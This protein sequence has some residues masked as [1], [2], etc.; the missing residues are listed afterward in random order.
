MATTRLRI[1][2][3]LEQSTIASSILYSNSSNEAAWFSPSL[4]SDRILF[5]D[6]SASTISWLSVGSGLTLS[7]TTISANVTSVNSQ[8][9]A[10]VLTTTSINEGTNLYFTDERVDDRVSN[11]L[12]A[13]TNITLTYNDVANTLTINASARAGGYATVQED[14]SNLTQRT[15]LNFVGAGITAS[16][17]VSKTDVTL[18]ATL[19]AL[20]AYNT[21]GLLT[22]T[23]ADTFTG[24]TL[25]APAA[26]ITITNPAGTA[27]NPTFAL[28]NDLAAVEALSGTGIAR[29]TGTDTWSVG[30]TVS[31]AEGGTG[32]TTVSHGGVLVGF[33]GN[34]IDQVIPSGFDAYLK[35]NN[36]SG[37]VAWDALSTADLSDNSN[38]AKL[39]ATQTFT[40]DNTFNNV[41]VNNVTPTLSTHLVNKSYVDNLLTGLDWKNSARVAS[42][43]NVAVTYNATG[44]TSARGQITGAPNTLDGI[45]LAANNRILLKDQSTGAQNG[46]WVVTTLGSG[47]N[48]VWDRA[49]DFDSDA[50]VTSGAAMF[51][52]EGTA[53]A[54]KAFVLTTNDPITI[55]G[56]SGT[57][58]TFVQFGGGTS[59]V[60]GAGLL[61]SG[62]ILN[63]QTASSARIV[64]N[65]DNIDLATTAVSSGTYGDATTAV[66]FSV[67]SYGRLTTATNVAIAVPASQITDFNEAAQDAVGNI[68]TDTA[69]IDFTYNDAGNTIT[70][71]VKDDSITFAKVQNISTARLLGRSTAG[72]GDI[73]QLTY[74][75]D[76]SAGVYY[77]ALSF[78]Y[79]QI[80]SGYTWATSEITQQLSFF[81]LVKG[82]GTL[83]EHDISQ[84]AIKI[85]HADTSSVSNLDTSAAQVIDTLTF[86]TYGHVQTVTTRNLTPADIGASATGH[87]HTLDDLSDVIIT[88][89][90]TDQVLKYNGTNWV[91]GTDTGGVTTTIGYIESS[92]ATTIDLDAN[93]GNVKDRNG[94]NIAFTIPTDPDKMEVFRNGVLQSRSGSLT[95]RDYQINTTTHEI[96]FVT[97]LVDTEVVII[98]K[99]E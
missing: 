34:I 15:T 25:T 13:G 27:G 86:D 68:L 22:Q 50:E 4:G 31:V 99:T 11:L 63:V 7:G 57:S 5:W 90:S 61:F 33:T 53:N 96:T 73:E 76:I 56:G 54:D 98:K 85:S 38:I 69:T 30:T 55:G 24:R 91:N 14:G 48:G 43:A 47:S 74:I 66:Q 40:G 17:N 37:T 88:S 29:R 12:V 78:T 65:A 95:T 35:W 32:L 93:V 89:P 39:N 84:N 75:G 52:T 80:D 94:N 97:A 79:T 45:S 83:L 6:D 16:D 58:L 64:V 51:V 2:K 21:N 49:T 72:T 9:G 77:P 10:V 71:D 36:G 20:A 87:T 44:G 81:E 67:D 41:I 3:Q 28:A 92:T 8:T 18:D 42:T 23:A 60:D 19:N 70:A 26:G 1:D 82:S 62:N 59:V 46:V